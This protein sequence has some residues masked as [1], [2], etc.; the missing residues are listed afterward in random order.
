MRSELNGPSAADVFPHP[1]YLRTVL[2]PNFRHAVKFFFQPLI[3]IN[4]AHA[5]MLALCGILSRKHLRPLLGALR[6]VTSERSNLDAYSFQGAEEDLYFFMER[7]L[8]E[9]CGPEVSGH[10]SVAR[11]RNDVDMTLYRMVLREELLRTASKV[12]ELQETLLQLADIHVSTILPVVTHTQLAQPTTLGHYLMAAAEFLERDLKRFRQAY[13]HVNCCPLGACVATTTG[14]AIDRH[15][16]AQLLGFEGALENAYGCIASVDYLVES[17]GTLSALM[18]NL[19]RFIQDLLLWTSQD[20]DL[21][22]LPDGFVQS[23]SIMPQKRNPVALEHLRILASN[24]VGQCQSIVLDLHNTPFGDIVD[25]EDDLQP[26]VRTAFEYSSRVLDLL[27]AV[28]GSIEVNVEKA[29]RK[30]QGGEITLSELADWMVQFRQ[31]P[32]RSAHKIVSRVARVL[33]QQPARRQGESLPQRVSLLLEQASREL[34]AKP[35]LVPPAR[36]S[37]IL[38][39]HHFVKVRK[40]FGGPAPAVVRRS[41]NRHRKLATGHRRWLAGAAERLR[42]YPR[43]LERA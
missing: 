33:R 43:H 31:I 36:I 17:V 19:G 13:A 39:P 10:L 21:I 7:R 1:E 29:L 25:T 8:E 24:S 2:E 26:V 9:I 41:I 37:R 6:Q 11:S 16:L 5:I 12:A 4:R 40:V 28:L 23:S 22:H 14:F 42:Q 38:D 15:R 3:E 34:W 35:I 27:T 18:I 30:C 32:F 20:V